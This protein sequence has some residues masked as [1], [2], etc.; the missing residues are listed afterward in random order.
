[1]YGLLNLYCE[2]FDTSSYGKGRTSLRLRHMNEFRILRNINSIIFYYI[3]Q[4][5]SLYDH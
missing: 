5:Y 2:I 3:P 4:K 1:M